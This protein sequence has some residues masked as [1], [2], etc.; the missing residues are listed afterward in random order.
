MAPD[1]SRMGDQGPPPR[2]SDGRPG[3]PLLRLRCARTG[4]WVPA[5]Q[6]RRDAG[7]ALAEALDLNVFPVV[8][9]NV[10]HCRATI[11][12]DEHLRAVC[13][14]VVVVVICLAPD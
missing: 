12:V 5:G 10:H 14:M 2:R 11:R 3:R 4:L 8:A 1:L 6:G 13:V 7:R 9:K